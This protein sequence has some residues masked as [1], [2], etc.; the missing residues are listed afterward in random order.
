MFRKTV[1]APTVVV[2]K[3]SL[4]KAMRNLGEWEVSLPNA[5][6]R[7]FGLDDR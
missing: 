6:G 5:V 7:T 2:S 3:A 4:D 1:V